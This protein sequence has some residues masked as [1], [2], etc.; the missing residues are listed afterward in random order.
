MTVAFMMNR[1]ADGVIGGV[2]VASILR[3][4]IPLV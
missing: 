4:L 3:V 1:M 2:A